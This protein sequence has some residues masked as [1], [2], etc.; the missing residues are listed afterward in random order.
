MESL[1][2]AGDGGHVFDG[3]A[4]GEWGVGNDGGC[5]VL[6]AFGGDWN[7]ATDGSWE[8]GGIGSDGAFECVGRGFDPF[9]KDADRCGCVGVEVERIDESAWGIVF[10]PLEG[11]FGAGGFF[12]RTDR[13]DAGAGR[14]GWGTGCPIFSGDCGWD[15]YGAWLS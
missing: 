2:S 10:G 12:A 5:A 9:G 13:V 3:R 8:N 1:A 6:G 7:G 11:A 4:G 15:G 14:D